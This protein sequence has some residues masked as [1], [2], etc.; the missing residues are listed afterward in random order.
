M[1]W[2]S[3]W[4]FIF[5]IFSFAPF[6]ASFTVWWISSSLRTRF[7]RSPAASE[8]SS[9]ACAICSIPVMLLASLGFL[10]A[11]ATFVLIWYISSSI[12]FSSSLTLSARSSSS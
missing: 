7:A 2:L 6:S 9:P 5:A 10:T 3:F 12:L 11:R 1:S 8:I 4:V